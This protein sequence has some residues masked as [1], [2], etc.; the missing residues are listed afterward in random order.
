MLV[1]GLS[2]LLISAC[3]E[4]T[5]LSAAEVAGDFERLVT[6]HNQ[7]RSMSPSEQTLACAPTSGSKPALNWNQQ[8]AESAQ[9]QADWMADQDTLSHGRSLKRRAKT[10]DYA[11]DAIAE[12]IAKANVSQE[13]LFSLWLNSAS[14]CKNIFNPSYTEIG[15]G[16][17]GAYWSVMFGTPKVE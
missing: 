3:A 12:N 4:D 2:A 6:L 8:L 13:Q 11:Y 15:I 5:Q 9:D 7:A 1:A 14:H 16:Q 17:Q 10:V